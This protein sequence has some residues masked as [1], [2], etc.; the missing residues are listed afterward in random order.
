MYKSFYARLSRYISLDMDALFKTFEWSDESSMPNMIY[1]TVRF[2]FYFLRELSSWN[3]LFVFYFTISLFTFLFCSILY[4]CRRPNVRGSYVVEFQS[5]GCP[6]DKLLTIFFSIQRKF[7]HIHG[8]LSKGMPSLTN[9]YFT[10]YWPMKAN[11]KS[12]F[13]FWKLFRIHI[14]AIFY[15]NLKIY[16]NV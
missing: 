15:L 12:N 2:L 8:L 10:N 9:L 6:F 5:H 1:H 13:I 11:L 4:V 14:N 7:H 16:T 3:F